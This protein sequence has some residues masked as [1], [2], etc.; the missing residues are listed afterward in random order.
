MTSTLRSNK[1]DI[2]QLLLE[3]KDRSKFSSVFAFTPP[4]ENLPPINLQ[5]YLTKRSKPLI[6]MS[7][8]Y[9][10]QMVPYSKTLLSKLNNDYN[11][12]KCGVD[13][14]DQVI[15]SSSVQ[16]KTNRWPLNLFYFIINIALT[17]AYLISKELNLLTEVECKRDFMLKLSLELT[18]FSVMNRDYNRLEK[19]HKNDAQLFLE[20]YNLNFS[21]DLQINF[22]KNILEEQNSLKDYCKE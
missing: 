15:S 1:K 12:N 22:A 8:F 18:L 20:F 19:F 7:S 13:V 16:R 9:S 4:N 14:V 11:S 21:T 10:N 5:S 17:N 6:F 2:P 3:K